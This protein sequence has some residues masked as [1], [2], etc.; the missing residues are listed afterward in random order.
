MGNLIVRQLLLFISFILKCWGRSFSGDPSSRELFFQTSSMRHNHLLCGKT[1]TSLVSPAAPTTHN[2]LL[3][4]QRV[5]AGWQG[6][7][8]AAAQGCRVGLAELIEG[9]T[10]VLCAQTS[11]PCTKKIFLIRQRICLCKVSNELV[12]K[13]RRFLG[14]CWGFWRK[15]DTQKPWEEKIRLA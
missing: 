13:L 5:G 9:V 1:I 15:H 3:V 14:L 10:H 6:C 2:H 8:G 7:V 4:L 12:K 11:C